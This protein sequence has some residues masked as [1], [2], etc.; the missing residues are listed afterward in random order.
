[1]AIEVVFIDNAVIGFRF[2]DQAPDGDRI[3]DTLGAAKHWALMT[4]RANRDAWRRCVLWIREATIDDVE[5]PDIDR[6]TR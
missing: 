6:G 3:H 4:A 2:T 5:H 1:M